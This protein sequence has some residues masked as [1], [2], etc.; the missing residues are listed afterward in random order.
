[1]TLRVATLPLLAAAL[2]LGAC[3]QQAGDVCQRYGTA[4]ASDCA[5][6]LECCGEARTCDG[7]RQRGI[8]VAAGSCTATT[9][10]VCDGGG[11]DEAGVDEAG[12]DEAGV[13][14]G[15]DAGSDAGTDAGFD[16]GTDAGSDAGFDAGSDAGFDAG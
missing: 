5:E 13:D 2:F 7:L 15:S 10:L 12:V 14:A 3:A 11:V 8:C 4:G 9:G 16:A 6:G 1:M